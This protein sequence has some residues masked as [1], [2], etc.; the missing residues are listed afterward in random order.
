MQRNVRRTLLTIG[1][2]FSMGCGN[3]ND[4]KSIYNEAEMAKYRST[5]EQIEAGIKA[6]ASAAKPTSAD[7]KAMQ[8][9]GKKSAASAAAV[10]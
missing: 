9:Q 5:P 7:I 4:A 2:L 1:C 10:R 8:E 6:A 3:D